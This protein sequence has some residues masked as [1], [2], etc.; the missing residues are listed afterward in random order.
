[1]SNVVVKRLP[2]VCKVCGGTATRF[3]K[4]VLQDDKDGERDVG[5]VDLCDKH[6]ETWAPTAL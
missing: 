5:K 1:M 2:P 6:W 3:C 4:V